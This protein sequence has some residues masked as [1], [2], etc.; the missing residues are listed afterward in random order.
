MASKV[1]HFLPDIDPLGGA[2]NLVVDLC[3]AYPDRFS[4]ILLASSNNSHL[5]NILQSHNV[6]VQNFSIANYLCVLCQAISRRCLLHF[7]LS[8][9]FY[10]ALLFPFCLKLYTEHNTYNK[11][12][13]NLFFSI[14]D[15]LIVYPI[16]AKVVCISAGCYKSLS[17]YLGYSS[18]LIVINN[19]ASGL[20]KRTY[21]QVYIDALSRYENHNELIKLVMTARSHPNKDQ[22]TL[23]RL[24]TL[25]SKLQLTLIG[26]NYTNQIFYEYASSLNVKS[27][28]TCLPY[29]PKNDIINVLQ[30]HHFYIQSSFI[31][32]FGIAAIEAMCLGIPTFGTDIDGLRNVIPLGN[33]FEVGDISHL[34]LQLNRVMSSKSSYLESSMSSWSKSSQFSFES[35]CDNHLL[36]YKS[37]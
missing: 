11:R 30:S 14:F 19:A 12:R 31:E 25:H 29:T 10:F 33:L 26:V 37:L 18:N 27:R 16:F 34:L 3:C 4:I 5:L 32:G 35:F 2:Q 23:I 22:K 28:L 6:K 7:H 20:F 15:K 1:Y 17:S 9:S 13:N 8:R 21:K 24:L 36:L